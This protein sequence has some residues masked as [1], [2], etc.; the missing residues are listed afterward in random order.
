MGFKREGVVYT[1][2]FF[3]SHPLILSM[4]YMVLDLLNIKNLQKS[5]PKK[6]MVGMVGMVGMERESDRI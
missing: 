1:I 4:I 3:L 5:H 6:G 2:P